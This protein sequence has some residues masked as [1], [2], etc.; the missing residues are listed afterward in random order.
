MI[1][2]G[3]WD[4]LAITIFVICIFYESTIYYK[5]FLEHTFHFI[6]GMENKKQSTIMQVNNSICKK[7]ECNRATLKSILDIIILCGR[8]TISLRGRNKYS[9]D[10]HYN[11]GNC[12]AQINLCINPGNYILKEHLLMC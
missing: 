6:A 2:I 3:H 5:N 4:V 9:T 11:L 1:P 7:I 10:S 12:N 8:Q